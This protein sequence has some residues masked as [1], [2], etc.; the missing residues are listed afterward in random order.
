MH[1][2]ISALTCTLTMS[3]AEV[4]VA[5]AETKIVDDS[6]A[7]AAVLSKLEVIAGFGVVVDT[8][9]FKWTYF[10]NKCEGQIV[11]KMVDFYKIEYTTARDYHEKKNYRAFLVA[12]C[13]LSTNDDLKVCGSTKLGD[14]HLF[15]CHQR[16]AVKWLGKLD[17]VAGLNQKAAASKLS[18]ASTAA[19]STFTSTLCKVSVWVPKTTDVSL[20]LLAASRTI[21]KGERTGPVSLNYNDHEEIISDFVQLN[22]NIDT[23]IDNQKRA[24]LEEEYEGWKR[25]RLDD[26][27]EAIP[28]GW[29]ASWQMHSFV[30]SAKIVH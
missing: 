27:F 24:L 12:M 8:K 15:I 22:E 3:S 30:H 10:W 13:K 4:K 5:S 11:E 20:K 29:K 14:Q 16:G 1:F 26:Q 6:A 23:L 17:L 9:S 19:A 18:K 7:A 2:F 21:N 25:D 28:F